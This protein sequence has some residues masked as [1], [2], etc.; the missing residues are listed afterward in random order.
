MVSLGNELLTK[1][2]KML[3]ASDYR[4]NRFPEGGKRCGGLDGV[5]GVERLVV[6]VE[7]NSMRDDV[8]GSLRRNGEL[9]VSQ[10][11]WRAKVGHDGEGP[12]G[13]KVARGECA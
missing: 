13:E 10:C 4:T 12:R 2:N 5:L 3:V 9:C 11:G 7:L 8:D 1:P 6:V